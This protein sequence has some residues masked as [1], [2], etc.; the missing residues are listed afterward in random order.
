[1]P[2]DQ[3]CTRPICGEW[4]L[5]DTLGHISDWE[6]V[7]VES[8]RQVAAGQQPDFGEFEGVEPRNQSFYKARRDQAW[9]EVWADLHA[10]HEAMLEQVG[11]LGE[12]DLD[13]DIV[14]LLGARGPVHRWV[15]IFIAHDQEHARDLNDALTP[16]QHL[17][18]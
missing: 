12:E 6:R 2:P 13:R 5:K 18:I 3:V 16:V 8:L 15:R 14:Y 4:T 9:D 1:M 17:Q 7:W 11:A 10:A